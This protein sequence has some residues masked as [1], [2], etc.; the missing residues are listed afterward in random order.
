M[1]VKKALKHLFF[2]LLVVSLGLLYSFA[3]ERNLQKKVTDVKIEFS[4][5]KTNFLTI[6]MEL[7]CPPLSGGSSFSYSNYQRRDR[8]MSEDQSKKKNRLK[9]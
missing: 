4:G 8:Q 3:S 1:K 6:S 2:L 9:P 7:P 5:E